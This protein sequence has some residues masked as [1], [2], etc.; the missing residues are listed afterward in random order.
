MWTYIYKGK[1]YKFSQP[2]ANP[3]TAILEQI[4]AET[5]EKTPTEQPISSQPTTPT[6]PFAEL[7]PAK[8]DLTTLF[9]LGPSKAKQFHDAGIFTFAQLAEA[10][11]DTLEKQV[12]ASRNHIEA[13]IKDA[14]NIMA[15]EQMVEEMV[16]KDQELMPQQPKDT[17]A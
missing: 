5:T 15:K 10:D 9:L 7:E 1:F 11:I 2:Q 17:E 12:S 13:W 14:Q 16:A 8:D 4:N 6:L 3:E